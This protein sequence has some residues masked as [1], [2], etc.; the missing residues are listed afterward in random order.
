MLGL[1][2]LTTLWASQPEGSRESEISHGE[3]ISEIGYK[4]SATVE[5]KQRE[6]VV[7]EGTTAAL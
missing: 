3:D 7:V 6:D 5:V 1:R 2:H 4:K